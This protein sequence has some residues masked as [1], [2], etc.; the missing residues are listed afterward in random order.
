MRKLVQ[1]I[2]KAKRTGGMA[3][4]VAHLLSKCEA[5]NSNLSTAKL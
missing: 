4:M 5:L 3:Q 1:K 2:T